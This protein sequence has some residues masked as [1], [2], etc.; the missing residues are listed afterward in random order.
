MG[1]FK[2]QTGSI[3]HLQAVVNE[4]ASKLKVRWCLERLK[5]ELIRQGHRNGHACCDEELNL[6]Q[7]SQYQDKLVHFLTKIQQECPDIIPKD[8]NVGEDYGI[9]RSFRRGA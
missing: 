3:N 1:R 5:D 8:V 9:G 4:T 7:A 2:D 6:A